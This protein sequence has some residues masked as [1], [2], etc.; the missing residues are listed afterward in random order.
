MDVGGPG[1]GAPDD[2]ALR[3]GIVL[4]SDPRHPAVHAKRHL[5]GR[6]RADGPGQSGGSQAREIDTV[7]QTVAERSVRSAVVVRQG[8]FPA[9]LSDDPLKPLGDLADRRLPRDRNEVAFPLG[10][11]APHGVKQSRVV[12]DS[13]G[14]TRHLG[15]DEAPTGRVIGSAP[16]LLDHA[17][18]HP[19]LQRAA[20]RTVHDTS[21]L[22][23]LGRHTARHLPT[24][25]YRSQLPGVSAT[26][27]PTSGPSE[28][29]ARRGGARF[30]RRLPA[31]LANLPRV[32]PPKRTPE[33]AE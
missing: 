13:F 1:V 22:Y 17:V 2:H 24:G 28:G 20:V 11:R 12:V 33:V 25:V 3:L 18:D 30:P 31:A 27:A 4:E 7:G 21:G 29:S 9:P 10:A 26:K 14:K 6:G 32:F 8:G 23:Q 19:N 15:T 16:N 5:S